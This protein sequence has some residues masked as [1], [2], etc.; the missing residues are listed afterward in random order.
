[1]GATSES[2]VD[3]LLDVNK[4]RNIASLVDDTLP[5]PHKA[6]G[7][8]RSMMATLRVPFKHFVCVSCSAFKQQKRTKEKQTKTR[9]H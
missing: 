1:M 2:D 8:E 7:K 5:V 3:V 9:Q 4:A 6:L